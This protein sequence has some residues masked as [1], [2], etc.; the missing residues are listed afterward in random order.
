M[1]LPLEG[2][3]ILDLSRYLPGPL[4]T[5]FLADYGAE[6]LKVEDPKGGDLGRSLVPLIGNTSS[7]FYSVNRNKKSI[8]LDLKSPEGKEI[9]LK[10]AKEYD[11][12]L[13]QFRP[14]VM[15]KMGLGYESLK[16]L[17]P[18]LIYCA[19]TGYG[20]TGPMCEAAGHDINFLNYSGISGITGTKLGGPAMSGIQIADIAGGCQYAIIAILLA[21]SA[22]ERT[23]YGQLCDVS[24]LDGAFSLMTYALG[25]WA[26]SGVEPKLGEGTLGGGYACY[27]T[28]ETKDKRYVC[29]GMVEEKFWAEFCKKIG[30]PE[31][32]KPQWDLS[33]NAKIIPKLREIML[34]KT[35]AEWLEFFKN[36]DIC[37]SAVLLASEVC[38]H[39]QIKARELVFEYENVDGSG[40]NIMLTGSPVKLSETP[41]KIIAKFPKLGEHNSEILKGLGYSNEEISALKQKG[42]L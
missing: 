6:V 41:A 42:V 32:I 3:K 2:I 34:E 17:N 25:E 1:S 4:C 9:F 12:V 23:G 5:Q 13:D 31:Y 10:L 8:T 37:F 35:Q 18:R 19:L 36:D 21:V 15:D 14:G 29:C 39:P 27:N 20:L 30:R 22:R 28:Y 40:K 11:I 26:G 16:K 33:E 38:N 7:R 24:M